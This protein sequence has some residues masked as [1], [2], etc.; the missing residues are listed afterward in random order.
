[1]DKLREAV[2]QNRK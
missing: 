1:M 2:L